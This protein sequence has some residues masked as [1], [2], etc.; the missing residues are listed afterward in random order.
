[1]LVITLLRQ[2]DCEGWLRF[3]IYRLKWAASNGS[4]VLFHVSRV[5]LCAC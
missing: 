1:V 4:D 2:Q 3:Y 5:D